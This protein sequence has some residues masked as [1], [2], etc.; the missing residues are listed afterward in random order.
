MSHAECKMLM[1]KSITSSDINALERIN[2][3]KK[4]PSELY[5]II[6]LSPL[7]TSIWRIILMPT[8][9]H[10]LCS[11]LLFLGQ[12]LVPTVPVMPCLA[13]PPEWSQRMQRR[14]TPCLMILGG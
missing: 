3:E 14:D 7:I 12:S 13:T 5:S 1:H 6:I 11:P 4:P 9:V 2:K 8:I 10:N